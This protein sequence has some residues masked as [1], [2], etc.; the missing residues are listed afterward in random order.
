MNKQKRIWTSNR[1]KRSDWDVNSNRKRR[2][3]KEQGTDRKQRNQKEHA[4]H[5]QIKRRSQKEQVTARYV[6]EDITS[7]DATSDGLK[8]ADSTSDDSTWRPVLK[9][10]LELPFLEEASKTSLV[11]IFEFRFWRKSRTKLNA[12]LRDSRSMLCQVLNTKCKL[13]DEF[14]LGAVSDPGR[15]ATCAL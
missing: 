5:N 15:I 9:W 14:M 3:H 1:K 12:F 4:R 2:S 13:D 6:A 7:D 8:T 10:V 11:Q